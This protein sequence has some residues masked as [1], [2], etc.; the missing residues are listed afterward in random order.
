M[1]VSGGHTVGRVE[2]TVEVVANTHIPLLG[3]L[4]DGG[5]CDAASQWAQAELD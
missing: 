1:P 2:L 4:Q 3:A 5:H